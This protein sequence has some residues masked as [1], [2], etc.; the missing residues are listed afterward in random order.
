MKQNHKKSKPESAKASTQRSQGVKYLGADISKEYLDISFEGRY[1]RYTNDDK[2]L[3]KIQELLQK[4]TEAV[5][6]AYESTGWLSRKLAFRLQNMGIAQ[7]CLNP[8]NVR[9]YARAMGKQAKTDKLDCAIIAEYARHTQ[10]E[11]NVSEDAKLLK[12]KELYSSYEFFKK[13]KAQMKTNMAAYTNKLILK[14]QEKAIQDDEKR[15][16]NL[17]KAMMDIVQKDKELKERYEFYLTLQGI[18]PC[19]SLAL[20][21]LLPELGEMNRRQ[22][23]AIVGLAPYNWESGKM[24]GK[25]I[26]RHGR[27]SIRKL[28]YLSGISALHYK[29]S[30]I[31]DYNKK[32]REAG[33]PAKVAAVAS[34]RKLLIWINS[35][36]KNWLESREKAKKQSE[37][38]QES[39]QSEKA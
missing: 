26:T 39:K 32:L 27:E 3:A 9:N 2:G 4:Q 7:V 25:R 10:A 24:N 12:L 23:A 5:L 16:S 33:K 30:P 34:A 21:C 17:E 18:G 8:L 29:E 20:I 6:F 35:Q 19:I 1:K 15:I 38:R 22:A 11:S 13:R 14:E 36:T 37:E 28:L 31:K